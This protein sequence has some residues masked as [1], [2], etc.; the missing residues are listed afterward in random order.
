MRYTILFSAI[1]GLIFCGCSKETFDTVPQLKFTSVNTTTLTSGSILQFTVSFTDKEGDV[2]NRIFVDKKAPECPVNNFEQYFDVPSFPAT[3][4][5]KG[6]IVITFGYN[7]EGY[8]NIPPTCSKNETAV[9]R[10]V[11]EDKAGNVSDTISSPPITIV[12]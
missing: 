1:L 4:N 10:F 12:Y 8:P 6:D 7:V 2:S 5:Q 3:S 9:F 11:L